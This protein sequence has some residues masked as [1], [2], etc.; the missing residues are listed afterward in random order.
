AHAAHAGRRHHSA[1]AFP[2]HNGVEGIERLVAGVRTVRAGRGGHQGVA[3]STETERKERK[4]TF[5][6]DDDALFN[7]EKTDSEPASFLELATALA[8]RKWFILKM[9]AGAGVIGV[10]WRCCFP[11]GTRR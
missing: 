2:D 7:A 10:I 5:V 8:Q 1:G 3:M 4:L 11:T 9:T 6:I